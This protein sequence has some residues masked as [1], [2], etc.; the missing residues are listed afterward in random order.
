MVGNTGLV[1]FDF[2]TPDLKRAAIFSAIKAPSWSHESVITSHIVS[3]HL[4]IRAVADDRGVGVP[5]ESLPARPHSSTGL[6]LDTV[7]QRHPHDGT[8]PRADTCPCALNMSTP[9][10]SQQQGN[11]HKV[12]RQMVHI[13]TLGPLHLRS[14]HFTRTLCTGKNCVHILAYSEKCSGTLNFHFST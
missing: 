2:S 8:R 11:K 13:V 1:C 9:A 3:G 4:I 10:L 14:G 5:Q 12:V 6:P 7:G